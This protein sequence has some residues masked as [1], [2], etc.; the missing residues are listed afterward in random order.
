[1][2]GSSLSL[3]LDSSLNSCK[4]TIVN[5]DASSGLINFSYLSCKVF[6]VVLFKPLIFRK[7]THRSVRAELFLK[8]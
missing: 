6:K 7:A 1:V 2:P 8:I 4:G 5:P 3:K